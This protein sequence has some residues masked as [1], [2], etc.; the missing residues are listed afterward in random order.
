MDQGSKHAYDASYKTEDL[1]KTSNHNLKPTDKPRGSSEPKVD[2]QESIESW[3]G[4]IDSTTSDN[5]RN[6]NDSPYDN[7]DQE[8]S[9]D[10]EK[11]EVIKNESKYNDDSKSTPIPVEDEEEN[12]EVLRSSEGGNKM[13]DVE[14]SSETEKPNE[15]ENDLSNLSDY[16]SEGNAISTAEETES[17]EYYS[18]GE[19]RDMNE[20]NRHIKTLHDY[21]SEPEEYNKS[22]LVSTEENEKPKNFTVKSSNEESGILLNHHACISVPKCLGSTFPHN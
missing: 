14:E 6:G 19:E 20:N 2:E 16:K 12:D 9:E 21:D 3:K 18:D 7:E 17:A 1:D 10:D 4:K 22:V 15:D 5:Y 13:K 11:D 8:N